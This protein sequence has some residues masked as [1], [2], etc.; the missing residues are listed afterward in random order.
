[1]D[2]FAGAAKPVGYQAA[3]RNGT[4]GI[5]HADDHCAGSSGRGP[6]AARTKQHLPV[7]VDPLANDKPGP[8]A[9]LDPASVLLVGPDGALVE[10]VTIAG[11]GEYVVAKAR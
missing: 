9:T 2:G 4:I 6:D 10:Q 8:G 7:T 1:M 11:E 5:G 3:D